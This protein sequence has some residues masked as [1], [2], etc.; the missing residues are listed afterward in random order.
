MVT[1]L[2]RSGWVFIYTEEKAAAISDEKHPDAKS[3]YKGVWHIFYYHSP[4]ELGANGGKFV[5]FNW[6]DGTAEGEEWQVYKND[7]NQEI[8][9]NFAFVPCTVSKI[10]I[11]YSPL[12]WSKKLFTLLEISKTMR[13]DY[14]QQVKTFPTTIEECCAPLRL[15]KA[16]SRPTKQQLKD[17]PAEQIKFSP[18]HIVKEFLANNADDVQEK[19]KND[20]IYSLGSM[21]LTAYS[22][23]KI[24]NLK[25][26]M[27]SKDEVGV[28]VALHDP[29]GIS[30]DL[31]SL[32]NSIALEPV[33]DI[34]SN[35]YAYTIYQ[36]IEGHLGG[37]LS[38]SRNPFALELSRKRALIADFDQ[39]SAK[40]VKNNPMIR[41]RG[42]PGFEKKWADSQHFKTLTLEQR[43]DFLAAKRK[44]EEEKP[45]TDTMEN[46]VAA[47]S[48]DFKRVRNE[49]ADK[50]TVIDTRLTTVIKIIEQWLG[51]TRQG[52]VARYLALLDNDSKTEV[53]E[54][55]IA[56]LHL[57]IGTLNQLMRGL[58]TSLPGRKLLANQ[59][60]GSEKEDGWW[61]GHLVKGASQVADIKS[62][63]LGNY[64]QQFAVRAL[65][66]EADSI[67]LSN[68]INEFFQ[69]I[70]GTTQLS[71]GL[72]ITRQRGA[73]A[74]P[75]N[76]LATLQSLAQMDSVEFS[77]GDRNVGEILRNVG[78]EI[79]DIEE[80]NNSAGARHYGTVVNESVPVPIA[81]QNGS[82]IANLGT[83]L[84]QSVGGI[85][86]F[87][88]C[89]DYYMSA[90]G[91]QE[92]ML[93]SNPSVSMIE[94]IKN[95]M[96]AQGAAVIENLAKLARK[97]LDA[98]I[99]RNAARVVNH[100]G[101][102]TSAM[103]SAATNTV[104]SGA[105]VR[106]LAVAKSLV[107]IGG[108]L[109]VIDVTAN[110]VQSYRLYGR[111]DYDAAAYAATGAIGGIAM[112][113]FAIPN[114]AG[115]IIGLAGV[116]IT[117]ASAIGLTQALDSDM[118]KWVKGCFWGG[119]PSKFIGMVPNYYY[120]DD[121]DRADFLADK[122][123]EGGYK[124]IDLYDA[125]LDISKVISGGD[126]ILINPDIDEQDV[127]SYFKKEVAGLNDI[128]FMPRLKKL[129]GYIYI[130]LPNY[131]PN[132]S[133]LEAAFEVKK[134]S[135]SYRIGRQSEIFRKTFP[136]TKDSKNWEVVH[137]KASTYKIALSYFQQHFASKTVHSWDSSG[138]V[139]FTYY[140]LG[141]NGD[142]A[143]YDPKIDS[144]DE[145]NVELPNPMIK[146]TYKL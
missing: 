86:L 52:G 55:Q 4:E 122:K 75:L 21:P 32:H 132:K 108:I 128:L 134:Y 47:L 133:V 29:I 25:H 59:L 81:S 76:S 112:M 22:Q 130:T 77:I 19:E 113:A 50:T 131:I 145:R 68:T 79:A 48:D 17:L 97:D 125:Q 137:E 6:P 60:F 35:T 7:N 67:N 107:K 121:A 129:D 44:L 1:R 101:G 135:G 5:K 42:E 82:N 46:A 40:I 88:F 126:S 73:A 119:K 63:A 80:W 109:G 117:V 24:E 115:I 16:K 116:G 54:Q 64:N 14:M 140:P 111:G 106:G 91:V 118:E 89:A 95:S 78:R 51:N 61:S 34:L 23:S 9:R 26:E 85:A 13:E 103:S 98:I 43:Q 57:L 33:H 38:N 144:N 94:S 84:D 74:D 99:A 69:H 39:Q 93:K 102:N 90:K 105:G 139:V 142:K 31:G 123:I 2:L 49:L 10:S 143:H 56:S 141:K 3:S 53:K 92:V 124:R 65:A 96:V 120:W 36:K 72:M 136:L 110:S 66:A 62:K 15:N 45:Y 41:V 27:I 30:A 58:S 104:R 70:S 127:S 87:I 138:A 114:P 146:G 11:A 12:M 100:L 8:I 83:N 37:F 20:D 18:Q 28:I 71:E